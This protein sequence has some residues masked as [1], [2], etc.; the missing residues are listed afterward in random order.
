MPEA[1]AL[2]NPFFLTMKLAPI[3]KLEERAK[4]KP[5]TLSEDKPW[6]Q[7]RHTATSAMA[8]TLT[9]G[10]LLD[11]TTSE[12]PPPY[13]FNRIGPSSLSRCAEMEIWREES[14]CREEKEEH[15]KSIRLRFE[16]GKKLA[17]EKYRETNNQKRWFDYY[18]FV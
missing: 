4:T 17:S 3:K 16:Y 11:K 7:L 15:K 10:L 9:P 6:A 2:F 8:G 5:L 18:I 12:N 14:R 13:P 1:P